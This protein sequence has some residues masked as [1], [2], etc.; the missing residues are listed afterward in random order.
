MHLATPSSDPDAIHTPGYAVREIAR[1][2]TVH[3]SIMTAYELFPF[4]GL[5]LFA[6]GCGD[7]GA[8]GRDG[9]GEGPGTARG[10][11]AAARATSGILSAQDTA[12]FPG[13]T[14]ATHR[15]SAGQ[16]PAILRAAHSADHP[17]YARIV[18][19]FEGP[20]VPGYHVEYFDTAVRRCGSGDLVELPGAG[21]LVV[22][23]EPAR[24]HDEGGNPTVI[25]RDRAPALPAVRRMV[26]ICDFEGQVTWA[27]GI[28]RVAPYR[29]LEVAQPS[30]LILDIRHSR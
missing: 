27:L 24:A 4:I 5:A 23:L 13:T 10:E 22:R 3:G 29:V 11:S 16:P 2:V 6:A 19:E 8:V 1:A 12:Q 7:D 15:P 14:A 30:R 18:F 20:G 9:S 28:D 21:R 25:D 26:M 17:G